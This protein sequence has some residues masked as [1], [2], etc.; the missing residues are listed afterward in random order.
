VRPPLVFTGTPYAGIPLTSTS[1]ATGTAVA[2]LTPASI[3][4]T[5]TRTV[6]GRATATRT[7]T[8]TATPRPRPT[9]TQ[10]AT[11][12]PRPT[13]RPRP[14]PTATATPRPTATP[15]PHLHPGYGAV[16]WSAGEYYVWQ[17]NGRNVQGT[18]WQLFTRA[19]HQW[20]DN[21]ALQETTSDNGVTSTSTFVSRLAFDVNTYL[22]RRYDALEDA[23]ASILHATLFGPH[24]DYTSYQSWA[25]VGCTA[26]HRLVPIRSMASGMMAD[27]LRTTQ[28]LAPQR[29]TYGV[30]NPYGT[31]TVAPA[32]YVVVGR[33]RLPTVL[34]NVPTVHV[35]LVEIP[36]P[37]LDVWYTDNRAH[38]VVKFGTRGVY[39]AVLQ[40]Y[41]PRSARTSLPVA[42]PRPSLAHQYAGCA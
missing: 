26:V 12:T 41:E 4:V 25:S 21:S 15:A 23:P 3:A 36:S 17:V 33:E 27:L 5:A 38:I 2:M 16:P 1:S 34:G 13:P 7:P 40:H 19:G 42:P 30:I 14:T 28:L 37:P 32:Y 10:R 39:G 11:P 9:P 24:L 22:L 29:S 31:V 35:R 20:A 6:V 8:S 18:A